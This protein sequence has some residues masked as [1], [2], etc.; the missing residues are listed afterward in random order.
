MALPRPG[1]RLRKYP[2]H[3]QFFYEGG[4]HLDRQAMKGSKRQTHTVSYL[5]REGTKASL[6]TKGG[7]LRVRLAFPGMAVFFVLG[8]GCVRG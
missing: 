5:K 8:Q 2:P 1:K 4:D 6:C 7:A 3:L